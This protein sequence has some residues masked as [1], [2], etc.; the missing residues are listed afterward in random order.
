MTTMPMVYGELFLRRLIRGPFARRMQSTK[1]Q[2]MRSASCILFIQ[3]SQ[4]ID[5][6][7]GSFDP[8]LPGL[9]LLES[10]GLYDLCRNC[11][12]L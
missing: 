10:G 1:F 6:P 12:I 7:T 11:G 3:L 2:P 8:L 5:E 4:E 9:D